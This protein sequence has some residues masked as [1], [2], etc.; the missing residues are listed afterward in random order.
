VARIPLKSFCPQRPLAGGHALFVKA[1]GLLA[2]GGVFGQQDV[3]ISAIGADGQSVL[4]KPDPALLVGFLEGPIH[5][6]LGFGE[7]RV[8]LRLALQPG[9]KLLHDA[10]HRPAVGELVQRRLRSPSF[11][12]SPTRLSLLPG[13]RTSPRSRATTRRSL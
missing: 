11:R 8:L 3:S 2:A 5:E 1:Q 6:R 4:R 13:H 12:A 7:R 10:F 9:D